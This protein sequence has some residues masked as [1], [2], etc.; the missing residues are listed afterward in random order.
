MKSDNSHTGIKKKQDNERE[1]FM[2]RKYQNRKIMQMRTSW[3]TVK[4]KVRPFDPFCHQF[5]K[6]VE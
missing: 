2:Y 4:L 5:K 6:K 3:K 1:S